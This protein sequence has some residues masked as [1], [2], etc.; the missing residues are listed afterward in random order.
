[1]WKVSFESARRC[2]GVFRSINGSSNG[3][4]RYHWLAGPCTATA[5]KLSPPEGNILPN[6]ASQMR[7]ARSRIARKTVSRSPGDVEIYV[8]NLGRGGFPLQRLVAFADQSREGSVCLDELAGRA[9]IGALLRFGLVG[10]RCRV[11]ADLRSTRRRRFI[12][13]LPGGRPQPSTAA[14]GLCSTANYGQHSPVGVKTRSYRSATATAGSP[15]IAD[16]TST[17]DGKALGADG[18]SV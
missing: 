16:I 1:M 9:A 4:R 11:F 14:G 3:S 12:L 15:Q 6:L 5:R 8:Q 13:A 2:R 17:V 18:R 10:L 7:V